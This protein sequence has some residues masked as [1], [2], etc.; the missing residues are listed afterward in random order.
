MK[1]SPTEKKLLDAHYQIMGEEVK[2]IN[3]LH[4]VFS[5]CILPYRDPKQDAYIKQSGRA[6][7][8]VQGGYLPNPKTS[9]PEFMGVPYGAKP[10]L[11]LL[12]LCSEAI[13]RRSPYIKIEDSMSGFIKNLGL[14]VSGGRNGSI[15]RFKD[16]LRKL[17]ACKIQ[18]N[19]PSEKGIS[20]VNASSIIKKCDFWIPEDSRQKMLWSSEVCLSNEFFISLQKHALPL[21]NR[22]IKAIQHNARALDTYT[23]LAHRL[24]R[25][26]KKQGDKVSWYALKTQFGSNISQL[27]DFRKTMLKTLKLVKNVYPTMRIK[28]VT[29][30]VLLLKSHPPVKSK[31]KI[32]RGS[33][34]ELKLLKK[35]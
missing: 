19:M 34:P 9:E 3:F 6:S 31:R 28:Q 2:E 11:I 24:P 1:L 7:I 32:L 5:Q 29:G 13:K 8:I 22:A 12:N 16:Q 35:T 23:W 26:R 33:R 14:P 4:S 18:V 10:R 25:V 21:D 17:I 30:G 20:T 27:K 15:K